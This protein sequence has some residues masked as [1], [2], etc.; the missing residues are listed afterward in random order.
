MKVPHR[1]LALA[2]VWTALLAGALYG[3]DR[4]LLGPRHVG[5]QVAST[6]E[7]IP[8]AAGLVP[9]PR[10]VPEHLGWPPRVI[11]YRT[12]RETGCWLGLADQ[13]GADPRL[14]IGIGAPPLPELLEPFAGCVTPLRVDCPAGWRALSLADDGRV[15]HVLGEL[16]AVE[17]RRVLKGLEPH[18][19]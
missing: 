12:G 13:G 15:I 10:I 1:R 8:S 7:E 18:A 17:M 3:A 6:I 5:W 16:P 14:W 4:F 9:T 2:L 19:R 11:L